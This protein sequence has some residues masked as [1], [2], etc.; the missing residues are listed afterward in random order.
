MSAHN[1]LLSHWEGSADKATAP[2]FCIESP[3]PTSRVAAF[4]NGLVL[5][6]TISSMARLFQERNA[7]GSET[8][9][10]PEGAD[11]SGCVLV[12]RVDGIIESADVRSGQFAGE[13][14]KRRAEL[15][16]PR[17]R[18]LADNRNSIVR[19]KVVT[20]VGQGHET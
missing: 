19:R 16:K 13:I 1:D 14:G 18:G 15:R 10:L 7:A 8:A 6:R 2:I 11:D 20:V 4:Y 12:L 9:G 3:F 5:L 17:E